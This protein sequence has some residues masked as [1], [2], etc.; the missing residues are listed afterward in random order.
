[1]RALEQN[2]IN[3]FAGFGYGEYGGLAVQTYWQA[4]F[5]F[6]PGEALI[7]ETE[8]PKKSHY[9]NVQLND[10]LPNGGEDI[11]RPS[12][13]KGHNARID[14]DGRFRAVIAVDDPGVPNWLD[15]GGFCEGN[16]LGRWYDCDKRPVP[17][18]KRVPFSQVREYLPADTPRVSAAERK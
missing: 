10:P 8:M 15:T 9:W 5:E 17:T 18:L 3:K 14:G 16:C 4:F 6:K 11:H 1:A 2:G 12:S 7:L 13:L